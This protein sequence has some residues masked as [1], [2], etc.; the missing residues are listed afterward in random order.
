MILLASIINQSSPIG[1]FARTQPRRTVTGTIG[2]VSAGRT[3]GPTASTYH[4]A[5]LHDGGQL[6]KNFAQRCNSTLTTILR[7][8]EDP[9]YWVRHRSHLAVKELYGSSMT[10][11]PQSAK[12]ISQ[13]MLGSIIFQKKKKKERDE[14]LLVCVGRRLVSYHRH[15]IRDGRSETGAAFSFC[16]NHQL[17]DVGQYSKRRRPLS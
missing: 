7:H 17:A 6:H 4:P 16:Q 15:L 9:T 12:I 8:A 2:S 5:S 11:P 13:L 14:M 1:P 10:Y 3:V